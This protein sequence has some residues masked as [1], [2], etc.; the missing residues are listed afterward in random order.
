MKNNH[1]RLVDENERYEKQSLSS[2]VDE[3]ER[4]EKQSLSSLVGVNEW[5]IITLLDSIAA[6]GAIFSLIQLYVLFKSPWCIVGVIATLVLNI[7][8]IKYTNKQEKALRRLEDIEKNFL[9]EWENVKKEEEERRCLG[10][11]NSKND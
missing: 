1:Y 10:E 7:F 3:N 6:T 8:R 4:Y 9:K 5:F 11:A 2:L